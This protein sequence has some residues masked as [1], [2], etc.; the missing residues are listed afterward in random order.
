MSFAIEISSANEWSICKCHSCHFVIVAHHFHSLFSS[1]FMFVTLSYNY[2]SMLHSFKFTYV[3]CLFVGYLITVMTSFFLETRSLSHFIF[4]STFALQTCS[5]CVQIL[6]SNYHFENVL[7]QTK[8]RCIIF[9]VTDI[10]NRF[11]MLFVMW[12]P[13]VFSLL[14]I[15]TSILHK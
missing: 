2:I 3:F 14:M 11:L 8:Y 15:K 4:C 12:F 1:L 5:K 10:S 6:T 13:C 9:N 7:K